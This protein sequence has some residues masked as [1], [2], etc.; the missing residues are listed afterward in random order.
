VCVF[1]G[2]DELKY[3]MI[4]YMNWLLFSIMLYTNGREGG[5]GGPGVDGKIS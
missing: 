4:N 2:R 3:R 5:G 1:I